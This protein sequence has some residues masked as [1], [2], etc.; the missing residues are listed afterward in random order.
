MIGC[1]FI[2]W[3]QE[4]I[5]SG[6]IVIGGDESPVHLIYG[7][8]FLATPTTF[9]MFCDEHWFRAQ[10]A[11]LSLQLH[12]R[13]PVDQGNFHGRHIKGRSNGLLSVNSHKVGIIIPFHNIERLLPRFSTHLFDQEAL[14]WG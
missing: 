12:E 3:L 14:Q 10:H 7:G 2:A 5:N 4:S 9:K 8:L 11:F 13:C 1:E 6:V